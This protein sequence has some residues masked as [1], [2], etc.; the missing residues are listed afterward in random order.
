M[1]DGQVA[2]SN[3]QTKQ[4]V[5]QLQGQ[6]EAL[7]RQVSDFR[8]EMV[9]ENKALR[10]EIQHLSV[11]F[12]AHLAYH[13]AAENTSNSWERR[14][15]WASTAEAEE[16]RAAKQRA[17]TALTAVLSAFLGAVLRDLP[18]FFTGLARLLGGVH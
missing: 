11:Q 17:V 8:A 14:H 7:I 4:E 12:A 16:R 2:G 6:M 15:A 1:A 3:G 13:K 9:T 18:G 10:E 5:G